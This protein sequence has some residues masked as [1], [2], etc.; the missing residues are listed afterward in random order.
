M[1]GTKVQPEKQN[2]VA[3]Q[4]PEPMACRFGLCDI[5]RNAFSV[6]LSPDHRYAAISDSVGRVLVVDVNRG[7]TIRMF[8]GYREAQCAF[9][10]VPNEKKSRQRGN[11][12]N[13]LFLV[14][15]SGKK[16]T[17]EVFSMQKGKKIVTF[18]AAKYSRLI[19]IDYGVMGFTTTTKS[20][21]VC[22]YTCT[23]MDNDGK[24]KEIIVPFHFALSEKNSSRV[25]DLHLYKRLKQLIKSGEADSF[26][27]ESINTCKE[28]HTTEMKLQCLE[29]LTSNKEIEAETIL[30]CVQHFLETQQDLND[31]DSD[32]T[33]LLLM[34][35]NLE[36]LL[37]FYTFVSSIDVDEENGNAVPSLDNNPFTMAA[38][39]TKNL[40]KLLD[41]NTLLE[42]S[43]SAELKVSF[44]DDNDFS[45][46]N[47][48]SMFKLYDDSGITLKED[49]DERVL[50]QSSSIIFRR[51]ISGNNTDTNSLK[52]HVKK[53]KIC[54]QDLFK[55]LLMYWANRPLDLEMN[56]EREMAN[57]CSVVLAL[58]QTSDPEEIAVEYNSTSKFW[59]KIRDMLEKSSR[60]FPA[61]TAAIVCQYIAQRIEHEREM[62][63]ILIRE[64]RFY[65]GFVVAFY[66]KLFNFRFK[67][68]I[69]WCE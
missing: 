41:L 58:A 3:L 33:T 1:T 43:K 49:L 45:V 46:S 66:F 12:K 48:I 23:L 25:R 29:M 11:T 64:T 19:Y 32:A 8:K 4:P 6:V 28:L 10:Q 63:V 15:Y 13:A 69:Y 56:L 17:L 54:T 61:L 30:L 36:S 47:F 31:A 16:G 5:R 2:S 7:V 60:P 35:K 24:I 50:Y 18:T 67:V 34:C 14:V 57:L 37:V 27:S 26:T 40:Q 59:S 53:S 21:Y 38:E 44:G 51:Y 20:R 22:P 55:L 39:Q 62:Q 9:I 52:A 42:N 68:G 65:Y